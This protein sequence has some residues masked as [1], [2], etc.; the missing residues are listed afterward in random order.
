MYLSR[1]A[2]TAGIAALSLALSAAPA[3]AKGGAGSGGDGGG[4]GGGGGTTTAIDPSAQ[5]WD[6]CPQWAQGGSLQP[7]GSS[8]AANQVTGV[9]CLVVRSSGGLL[10]IY[11]IDT[12]AGWV[13]DIKAS[14]PNKIDVMWTWPA[15]GEKHEI[16]FQPGK[17]VIR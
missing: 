13:P 9:G 1:S 11:E 17:T 2:V 16:T 7:D 5:P 12:A 8:L 3:L 6:I 4:G 10:S 15:T 14:D